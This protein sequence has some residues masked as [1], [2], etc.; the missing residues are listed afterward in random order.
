MSVFKIFKLKYLIKTLFKKETIL[1]KALSLVNE[2]LYFLFKNKISKNKINTFIRNLKP[3]QELKVI[4][5]GHWYSTDEWLILT[6]DYQDIRKPLKFP[7]KSVDVIFSEHVI[8]HVEF[9]DALTF[10]RE[11]KRILKNRGI[12]RVICPMIDKLIDANLDDQRGNIYVQNCLLNP[13]SKEH[14]FLNELNL[15]GIF[16]APKTFLLN[17][18]FTKHE[19]KFIWSGELMVKI[20]KAIG[21]SKVSIRNIG[22]GIN[23]EYCIERRMRGLYMG[24]DFNIDRSSMLVYD[25]ESKVVEAIK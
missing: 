23:E 1:W 7:N 21:F 6:E 5:G 15:N 22:E 3:D 20:L 13:Y 10:F 18:I 12:F 8:E 9:T 16:E 4:F 11:S 24:H 14:K 19:H 25:P 2:T 17:S